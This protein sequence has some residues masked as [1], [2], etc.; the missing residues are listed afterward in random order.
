MNRSER[1]HDPRRLDV[2][3]W[4]DD[5]QPL[6]GEVALAGLPRLL[7]SLAGGADAAGLQPVAWQ[8][9]VSRRTRAGARPALAMALQVQAH[10]PLVCQR[11]LQA[12]VVPLAVDR[13]FRFAATEEEAERLDNETEDDVLVLE[14]RMNLLELIE[15][16]LILALPIVARHDSCPQPLPMAASDDEA[17][18]L[19]EAERPNPFAALAALKSN[20]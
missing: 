13:L 4:A 3:A 2:S 14:R 12:V 10:V 9:Q 15:D 8:A 5:D 18:A 7:E 16:E 11:C 19:E 20:K 6:E 1:P 17:E